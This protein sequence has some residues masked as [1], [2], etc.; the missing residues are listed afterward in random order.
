MK[1]CVSVSQQPMLPPDED[2]CLRIP[3]TR[4]SILATD[5]KLVSIPILAPASLSNSLYQILALTLTLCGNKTLKLVSVYPDK[6][7][8]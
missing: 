4:V 7:C 2:L 6:P 3:T 5:A 8:Y 1:I